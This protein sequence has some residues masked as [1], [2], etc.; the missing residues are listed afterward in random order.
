MAIFAIHCIGVAPAAP[1]SADKRENAIARNDDEP[2][3]EAR[4][5]LG[6]LLEVEQESHQ[7]RREVAMPRT[8]RRSNNVPPSHGYHVQEG[9]LL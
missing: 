1:A 2:Q 4:P 3:L 6:G 8:P 7:R 5:A 9:P